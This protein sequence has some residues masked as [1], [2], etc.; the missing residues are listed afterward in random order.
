ML[1]KIVIVLASFVS[2]TI[3]KVRYIMTQ[4]AKKL[5][6]LKTGGS[7]QTAAIYT[8]EAE[9]PA[10]NLKVN[11]DGVNGFIKLGDVTS[12]LATNG[13][14]HINSNNTDYAILSSAAIR[15]FPNEWGAFQSID[16]TATLTESASD[17]CYAWVLH[18]ANG[19]LP[20][21]IGKD[22]AAPTRDDNLYISGSWSA[23]NSISAYFTDNNVTWQAAIAKDGDVALKW[24]DKSDS[25]TLSMKSYTDATIMGFNYGNNTVFTTPF[26][27]SASG[28]TLNIYKNSVLFK[29][30]V[31]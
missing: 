18:F 28:S 30:Y 31:I 17:W 15:D 6:I 21:R 16:F 22:A 20:M 2:I 7:E 12:P 29:T 9:C 3:K 14:V 24:R 5:H 11:V 25:T 13:R 10:P 26:S 19:V 23:V 4:L 8:T 1:K 27:A